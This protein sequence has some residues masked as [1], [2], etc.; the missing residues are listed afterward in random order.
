MDVHAIAERSFA[1]DPV[2]QH[3]A[4]LVESL[5]TP[6]FERE[7]F[8]MVD[9]TI[10]CEHLTAFAVSH[11]D[12]PRLLLA[13]N[14]GDAPIAR[15]AAGVY[16][17][18]HW[19]SDPTNMILAQP[20]DLSE[21]VVACVSAEEMLSLRYRR[22][23]YSV[24]DW[25]T[26]GSSLIH[27][28]TF[29]K[30]RETDTIKV[31]FYRRRE[32]GPFCTGDVQRIAECADLLL[33]FLARH[34]PVDAHASALTLRRQF[35]TKLKTSFEGITPREAEVCAAIAVGMSSEAISLTLNISLNTFL[36][37]RKRA[38]ARLGI[39][40]QNELVRLIYSKMAS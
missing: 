36:T 15:S 23:C 38:Y 29:I 3:V 9:A 39:C 4:R 18:K 32:T 17:Q 12:R 13:A 5:G 16:L 40:S 28:V 33:A 2:R 25:A 20:R 27:K 14:R 21:G 6:G 26:S 35:Q 7:F 8:R 10:G 24:A 22:Q 30:R 19:D 11:P 1:H 31:H 37:Y 34:A